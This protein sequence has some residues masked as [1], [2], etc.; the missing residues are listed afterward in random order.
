MR[1]LRNLPQIQFHSYRFLLD[2]PI[3]YHQ[4]EKWI[5][6]QNLRL[7]AYYRNEEV[8]AFH[9]YDHQPVTDQK[10]ICQLMSDDDLYEAKKHRRKSVRRPE[11]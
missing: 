10:G 4:N 5:C 2:E 6:P 11:S 9:F 7:A 8:D 1:L 3:V